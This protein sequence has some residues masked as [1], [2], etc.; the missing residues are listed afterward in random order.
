M[1]SIAKLTP[2][3]ERYYERS[4]AA[5]LDD[6]YEG[7]GESP[8]DWT[9]RG[10]RE[11]VRCACCLGPIENE[12]EAVEKHGSLVHSGECEREWGSE[13]DQEEDA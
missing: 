11:L 7:R 10:A 6:Y 3:Q 12:A 1:L 5:G 8:G 4:V 9:G 2:G 13:L